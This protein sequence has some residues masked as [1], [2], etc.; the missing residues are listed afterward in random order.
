ME[1]PKELTL[2]YLASDKKYV[3]LEHDLIDRY[4]IVCERNNAADIIDYVVDNYE[5]KDILNVSEVMGLILEIEYQEKKT[6]V[7]NIFGG[8]SKK[9]L[10]SMLDYIIETF[11]ITGSAEE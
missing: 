10:T 4:R 2:D 9:M 11:G 1:E 8:F 6:E 5:E 7:N 3:L